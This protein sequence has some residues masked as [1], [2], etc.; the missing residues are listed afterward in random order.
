MQKPDFEKRGG[1]LPV[2]AQDTKTKEILMLAY[3]NKQAYEK[4]LAT[5]IATYYST[6][7]NALWVKGATSGNT[8]YVKSILIDCDNDA[9][10]YKVIQKGAGACHTG[11]RTC[12]W[13]VCAFKLSKK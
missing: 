13:Q 2:V 7:R 11:R 6:S 5:G 4:T 12:F 3:V 10:I 8:Q 1:L 9:L